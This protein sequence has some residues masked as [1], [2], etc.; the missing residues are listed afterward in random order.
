MIQRRPDFASYQSLNASSSILPTRVALNQVSPLHGSTQGVSEA[1][2]EDPLECHVVN[3]QKTC[4]AEPGRDGTERT[5][6]RS[7]S[8]RHQ[9]EENHSMGWASLTRGRILS[10]LKTQATAIMK[11]RNLACRHFDLLGSR[12]KEAE[13]CSIFLA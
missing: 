6:Q 1:G 8:L 3:A 12:F 2:T 4:E 7:F 13:G 5:L 11:K 9:D 10:M